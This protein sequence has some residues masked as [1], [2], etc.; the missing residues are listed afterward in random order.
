MTRRFGGAGLGLTIAANLVAMMGGQLQV[1]SAPGSGSTF[2][3]TIRMPRAGSLPSTPT[4]SAP[5]SA[6]PAKA[7]VALNILLAEDTYA[8]QKL[9]TTVL[10]R[11]GH[12]VLVVDNGAEAVEAARSGRFDAILMDIQMPT[13]DGFEATAAIRAIA[14][15]TMAT[16]PIVALTAHAMQGDD[17]RCLM[18][19]MDAYLA[20]PIDIRELVELVEDLPH[21]ARRIVPV[22]N[23]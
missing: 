7:S 20:K 15:P 21:R 12:H 3:F 13:M 17:A 5:A 1:E 19:G 18:A 2:S 23:T 11:R 6:E 22:D 8:N 16:V 4:S 10:R 14:D 9:L